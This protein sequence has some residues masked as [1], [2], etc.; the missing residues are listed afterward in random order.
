MI[1]LNIPT[2]Q[3]KLNSSKVRHRWTCTSPLPRPYYW[4]DSPL[5][6]ASTNYLPAGVLNMPNHFFLFHYPTLSTHTC[7]HIVY[8]PEFYY[9]SIKEN[10]NGTERIKAA[11]M[12]PST[13]KMTPPVRYVS[14]GNRQV[15]QPRCK[16]HRRGS[17]VTAKVVST[18]DLK[19]L[20]LLMQKEHAGKELH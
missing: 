1:T 9:R 7:Q 18:M 13:H 8:V 11:T 10:R 19:T 12:T 4:Q 2:W 20:K 6:R 5:I 16:Q 15:S 14:P 17:Q 3:R